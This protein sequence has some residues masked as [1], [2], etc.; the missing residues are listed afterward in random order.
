MFH[1]GSPT[2]SSTKRL[3]LSSCV[4]VSIAHDACRRRRRMHSVCYV[5]WCHWQPCDVM[6]IY[7][8][9]YEQRC[10]SMHAACDTKCGFLL[11]ELHHMHVCLSVCSSSSR[12][13]T[14]RSTRTYTAHT[15]THIHRH[16][17]RHSHNT[18][19][20]IHIHTH[21]ESESHGMCESRGTCAST[22]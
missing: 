3:Q 11:V 12:D 13:P 9:W 22:Q 14:Q 7:A 19:I 2:G 5:S 18:H 4:V 21:V 15:V 6:Y 20:H 10:S 16:R 1:W 17:H 8:A